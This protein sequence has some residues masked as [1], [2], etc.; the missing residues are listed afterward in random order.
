M[1]EPLEP[2]TP[3]ALP[4]LTPVA[5]VEGVSVPLVQPTRTSRGGRGR[6]VVALVAT[7]VVV[8][9]AGGL[10]VVA[11]AGAAS[12]G[13]AYAPADAI[14]YVDARADLPG[15]QH[16]QLATFMARFPGFA[17]PSSLDAKLDQALDKLIGQATGGTFS[18]T[19]NIKPWFGGQVAVSVG[20]GDA[21]LLVVSVS[22]SSGL[23]TKL[24][25]TSQDLAKQL[26]GTVSITDHN[27]TSV[28][29]ISGGTGVSGLNA[30]SFAITHDAIVA[31]KDAA[32]VDAALDR[33]AGSSPNLAGVAAY[34]DAVGRLDADRLGTFYLDGAAVGKLLASLDTGAAAGS[35]ASTASLAQLPTTI[36]GELQAQNGDLVARSQAVLPATASTIPA[37]SSD[38]ASHVP[39]SA[40]YYTE[41]H[42]FASLWNS[43]T[44]TLVQDPC[45][46]SVTGQLSTIEGLLGTKIPDAFAWVKD[47]GLVVTATGG[48]A[49]GGI[50]AT[51]SD[52]ATGQAR[53]TQLV[54]LLKLAKLQGGPT[55]TTSDTGYAGTTITSL[56][57][58]AD[59]TNGLPAITVAYAFKGDVFVLGV[60]DPFVKAV[61]DTTSATSLASDDRYSAALSAAGGATN[62]GVTYADLSAIRVLAE[63]QVPADQKAHYTSD[64]QPYL[65]PLDRFI[66]VSVEAPGSASTTAILFTK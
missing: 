36:A 59:A 17:D 11:G 30:I 46:S 62:S 14:L 39:G 49:T 31:A 38:L 7:L 60:G 35:C 52:A 37:A 24:D 58:A 8:L 20:P 54:T 25:Q 33:K 22:D 12:V 1:T 27:G 9:V 23:P 16:Q 64:V 3:E 66:T 65:V 45:L 41:V 21:V 56:N 57:V 4:P 29:T 43:V 5:R 34:R 44:T 18:Y 48:R 15:D 51:T 50:V 42:G 40:V 28:Y 2:G 26:G 10:I 63:A 19:A 53:L 6:W 61:L 32:T 47:A 55:I 13:P